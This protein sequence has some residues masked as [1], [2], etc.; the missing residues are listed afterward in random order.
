[1]CFEGYVCNFPNNMKLTYPIINLMGRKWFFRYESSCFTFACISNENNSNQL[2]RICL[3]G[4]KIIE[5]YKD[6]APRRISR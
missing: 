1:M 4:P 6:S 5:I 2:M 3:D